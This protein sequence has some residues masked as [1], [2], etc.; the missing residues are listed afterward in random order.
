[1]EPNRRHWQAPPDDSP[2]VLVDM[3][4]TLADVSHRVHHV[5]GRGRKDWPAFFR[6]MA[7]DPPN[8]VVAGWV[9]NLKPEYTIVILSG[10]PSNY[11]GATVEWLRRHRIPFDHLLMRPA[12]DHRPD[13]VVKQ[14]LMQTLPRE[15]IAFVIDDRAS[16]CRMW[17]GQGLRVFQVAEGDF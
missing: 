12:G 9:R 1:M 11:A 15:R 16:V 6:G 10:R 2:L 3:D 14:E 13:H 5:R 4:G 8:E 17:R 7:K